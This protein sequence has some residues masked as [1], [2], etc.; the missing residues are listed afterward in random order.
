[1][2]SRYITHSFIHFHFLYRFKELFLR[3]FYVFEIR[4][5]SNNWNNLQV[6]FPVLE[7]TLYKLHSFPKWCLVQSV[8]KDYL[9]CSMLKHIYQVAIKNL[10]SY[11]T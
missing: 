10:I 8:T 7:M 6:I 11:Q 2:A 1:M 5:K 3:Q 4:L 9:V